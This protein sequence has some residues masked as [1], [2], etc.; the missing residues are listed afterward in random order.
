MMLF[1]K[2]HRGR[3]DCEPIDCID[4]VPEGTTEEQYMMMDYVPVSF[5]C[6]GFT[7]NQEIKQDCYRLCFKNH[8]FDEMSDNDEQDLTHMMRVMSS[9][10]AVSATRKVKGGSVE[11]PTI[12]G[13]G[14]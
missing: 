13:Q 10:L 9:A 11:V 14:K 4:A 12:Q 6:S 2:C 5:V 8:V 1:P 3:T 7:S